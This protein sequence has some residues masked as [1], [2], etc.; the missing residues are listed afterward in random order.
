MKNPLRLMAPGAVLVAGFLL[1]PGESR[2][3]Q[4]YTDLTKKPCAYCHVTMV[5]KL[6]LTDAGKYFQKH[7][8]FDGYQPPTPNNRK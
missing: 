6:L 3:I 1:A 4:R 2:A 8:T 7:H 5:N